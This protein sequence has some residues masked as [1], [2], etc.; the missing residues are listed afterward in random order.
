MKRVIKHTV[1]ARAKISCVLSKIWKGE[2]M[3]RD[4]KIS[5]YEYV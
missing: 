4:V 5:M 1:W 3:L 2:E